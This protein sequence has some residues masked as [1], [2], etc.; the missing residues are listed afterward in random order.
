MAT[1][2]VKRELRKELTDALQA[3][4]VLV[5]APNFVGGLDEQEVTKARQELVRQVHA[6][7]KNFA[8][9]A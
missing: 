2:E 5:E 1:E 7:L 3:L 9:A 6:A 4:R 8:G